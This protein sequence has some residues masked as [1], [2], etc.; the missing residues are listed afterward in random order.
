[1]FRNADLFVFAKQ[2]G[3]YSIR[4][5]CLRLQIIEVTLATLP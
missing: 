1:M 5:K 4:G 3:N 2:V